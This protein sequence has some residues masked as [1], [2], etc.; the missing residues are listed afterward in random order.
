MRIVFAGKA[1]HT[2][3][4]AGRDLKEST[5]TGTT[6]IDEGGDTKY[7]SLYEREKRFRKTTDKDQAKKKGKERDLGLVSKKKP[8]CSRVGL[9]RRVTS[10]VEEMR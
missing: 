9:S 4:A 5:Q 8:S 6:P 1:E 7:P 3:P 10:P 2:H